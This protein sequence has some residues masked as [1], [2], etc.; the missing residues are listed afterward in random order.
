MAPEETKARS[1]LAERVAPLVNRI[2][3]ILL[4]SAKNGLNPKVVEIA[5]RNESGRYWLTI[6]YFAPGD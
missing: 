1:E 4:D 3:G 5:R 2:N 6:D